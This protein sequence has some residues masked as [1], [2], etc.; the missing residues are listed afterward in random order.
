MSSTLAPSFGPLDAA[1]GAAYSLLSH[2]TT[3]LTPIGG[4]AAAAI[5][6]VLL[7][8]AVRLLLVP[9]AIR[10]HAAQRRQSALAPRLKELRAKHAADPARLST[11]LA[12]LYRQE[13]VSPFG[14]LLV[15][16]L[17]APVF[18][19]LWMAFTRSTVDGQ[20]NALLGAHLFGVPLGAAGLHAGWPLLV[21]L[22]AIALV[23]TVSARRI[24]R[25]DGPAWLAVLPYLTLVPAATM[26][27]AAGLYLLT[28]TAWSAAETAVIRRE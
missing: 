28:T 12:A 7:T 1:A 6:V 24:R 8:A 17:Q 15:G 3:A 21:L 20:P 5:A 19:V 16:L 11:E 27:L 10:Q 13:N 18:M 14:G 26:P 23:A 22:A 2:L 25:G 4:G 9:L